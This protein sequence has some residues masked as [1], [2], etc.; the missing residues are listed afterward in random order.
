MVELWFGFLC[1]TLMLFA[2]LDGWN[3][4]A[5]TLH[6]IVGRSASER[7]QIVAALGP[8]WSWHEVWLVAFGGT[9]LLAFPAVMATA[10]AGFYLALW[11]VLWSLILRGISLEVGG[12]SA[13]ALWQ[14][15]WDFVFA[16]SSVVLALL[17]G[18][19]LGNVIRGVPLDE[20]GRFS[21]SLFTHFGVRGRVGILDWYT[22]SFAAFT[23]VLLAAHGAA[24]LRLKTTGQVHDRSERLARRMWTLVSVLFLLVSVETWIV[25][26]ALYVGMLERPAAWLAISVALAGAWALFTGL[27]GTAER[28]AFVG[29]CAV[30]VGLLAGAAAGVFPVMLHSTLGSDHSITA[31]TGAA[32]VHGLAVAVIWWPPALVLAIS[33]FTIITR[34]YRGKVRPAKDTQRL[35]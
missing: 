2:V 18:V 28:R 14:T 9:F 23:T 30:I 26:P 25:R 27:R 13:D 29:S 10:F 11:F 33:Y 31:Y 7:R 34:N 19:A 21:M 22:L 5:G 20:T 1:L 3:I 15:W 17:F 24:Y 35:Y 8:L 32:P 12:H 16:V 4:G 6:L